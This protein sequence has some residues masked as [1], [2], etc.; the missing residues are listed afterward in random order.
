MT[1]E[2]IRARLDKAQAALDKRIAI[3]AKNEARVAKTLAIC[4]ANGWDVNADY[5]IGENRKALYAVCD[6]SN[7]VDALATSREKLADAQKTVENW[8]SKLASATPAEKVEFRS[9]PAELLPLVDEIAEANISCLKEIASQLRAGSADPKKVSV[10]VLRTIYSGRMEE[11]AR[12]EAMLD[13]LDLVN[14]C[15][16]VTGKITG[17]EDMSFRQGRLNGKV[18]GQNGTANV[19]SIL[20]GGY[21]IQCLHVRTLVQAC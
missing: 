9:V 8:E 13:V 7:A 12:K 2:D 15:Y 11:V 16:R 1:Q 19:R 10:E 18:F 3:V 14:R 17:Y 21:N 20:A 5:D 4:Q 6:Y